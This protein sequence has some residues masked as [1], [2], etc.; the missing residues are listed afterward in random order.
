VDRIIQSA[1]S[2]RIGEAASLVALGRAALIKGLDPKLVLDR[3]FNTAKK[4]DPN[5]REVY[6]AIGELALEK[7]DFGL[8]A[9][10]F[11]EGLKRLPDVPD[12]L[13][14]LA[15][16]YEPS[17]QA[18]MVETLEAALKRNS[19]HVASLLLLTD[20]AIDAEAYS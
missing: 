16:A 6:L 19:N 2:G 4:A 13:H 10:T 20:H 12:L 11:Q 18:L 3:M 1:A 15:R 14:G 8:A 17:E 5:S 9:K 7:H